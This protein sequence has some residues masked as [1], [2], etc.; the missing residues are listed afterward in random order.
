MCQK[1]STDG[2]VRVNTEKNIFHS[3]LGYWLSF[4]LESVQLKRY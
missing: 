1:V 4:L 3:Y 2:R